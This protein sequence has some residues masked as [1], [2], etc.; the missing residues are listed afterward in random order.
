MVQVGQVLDLDQPQ[1][2]PRLPLGGHPRLEDVGEQLGQNARS[3]VLHAQQQPLRVLQNGDVD[4]LLLSG[5]FVQGLGGVL[6]QVAQN[7]HHHPGGQHVL[8]PGQGAS[9]VH[10]ELDAQLGGPAGL[11]H[12][13]GGHRRVLDLVH[14]P[15]HRLVVDLRHVQDILLRLLHPVQLN[16]AQ[17]GVE[18]V[19]E[20][21]GIGP[22]GLHQVAAAGEGLGQVGHLGA[23][24]EHRHR[25][26]DLPVLPNGH[27]VG[28]N[29]LAARHLLQM[30]IVLRLSGGE[31]A[32]QLGGGVDLQQGPPQ[33]LSGVLGP[34]HPQARGV[35]IGDHAVPVDGQNALVQGLQ[36]VLPLVEE[37]AE[38]VGL[39]AHKGVLDGP[40]QVPGEE[41]AHSGG[42]EGEDGEAG[43]RVDDRPVD[44][45]HPD[46]HRDKTQQL[47]LLVRHRGQGPV[48]QLR[49]PGAGIHLG[50]LP[51]QNG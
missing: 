39:I 7:G 48:L 2:V 14:H 40:R 3:G 42:Q 32:G 46:A 49:D 15:A 41:Q 8:L 20:F 27:P 26:H 12:Q 5:G 25:P 29:L 17:D 23:V 31:Q 9:G 13:Q 30:D 18:L 51:V 44:A 38:H 1:A 28:Q 22:H 21:V 33:H 50:A 37:L 34:E 43:H 10:L 45:A 4:L 11:A 47:P 35:H 16:E 36:N 24:P 6:D 19:D